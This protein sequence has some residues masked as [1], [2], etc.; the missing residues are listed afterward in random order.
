MSQLRL[1]RRL[2]QVRFYRLVNQNPPTFDFLHFQLTSNRL[3]ST[4]WRKKGENYHLCHR[5]RQNPL[6]TQILSRTS[7]RTGAQP[8]AAG[9]LISRFWCIL[10]VLSFSYPFYHAFR[11]FSPTFGLFGFLASF[12]TTLFSTFHV[13]LGHNFHFSFASFCYCCS[14]YILTVYHLTHR[15]TKL[16]ERDPRIVVERGR[17][18]E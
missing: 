16:W 14:Y 6:L 15:E 7:R 17:Q 2:I 5:F 3:S 8:A 4:T 12:A 1:P 11:V 13:S 18:Q 10:L 9:Q